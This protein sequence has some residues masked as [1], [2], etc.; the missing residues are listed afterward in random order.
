MILANSCTSHLSINCRHLEGRNFFSFFKF[1]KV[2]STL[3]DL[4][5]IFNKCTLNLNKSGRLNL[6]T[7]YCDVREYINNEILVSIQ[8]AS[9]EMDENSHQDAQSVSA[10]W[11]KVKL[12]KARRNRIA[13]VKS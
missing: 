9:L 10:Q 6:C 2:F 13:L 3:P 12:P 8:S 1:P 11:P 7:K 5:K 4:E